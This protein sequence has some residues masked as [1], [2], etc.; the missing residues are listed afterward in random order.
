M[1]TTIVNVSVNCPEGSRAIVMKVTDQEYLLLTELSD[2]LLEVDPKISYL[3]FLRV[4]E[5]EDEPTK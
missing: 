4:F 1:T 5:V 3:P 2:R